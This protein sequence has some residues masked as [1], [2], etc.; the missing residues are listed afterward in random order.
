[1]KTF[2]WFFV[3]VYKDAA[4]ALCKL[5]QKN[6][7]I[8]KQS[9]MTY[10]STKYVNVHSKICE[11][12][13]TWE[14]SNGPQYYSSQLEQYASIGCLKANNKNCVSVNSRNNHDWGVNFL[15]CQWSMT[16]LLS[17][18]TDLSPS[19]SAFST[20]L[21]WTSRNKQR[22]GQFKEYSTTQQLVHLKTRNIYHLGSWSSDSNSGQTIQRQEG[23]NCLR[24]SS[25]NGNCTCLVTWSSGYGQL[26][27]PNHLKIRIMLES[28]Y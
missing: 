22:H 27:G 26:L 2:L 10:I 21:L 7:K 24:Q 16:S 17:S 23:E 3:K 8:T 13:D 4:E 5:S 14:C 28:K 15:I 6:H 1:M 12:G 20:S 19:P 25:R 11:C 18:S 9:K